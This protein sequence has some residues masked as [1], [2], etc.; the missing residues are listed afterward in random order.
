MQ[1]KKNRS[2]PKFQRYGSG[3]YLFILSSEEIF[4]ATM[5]TEL[6]VIY[7]V[8]KTGNPFARLICDFIVLMLALNDQENDVHRDR[9]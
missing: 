7:L 9:A 1:T 6:D 8:R 5:I 2:L 3:L 4:H